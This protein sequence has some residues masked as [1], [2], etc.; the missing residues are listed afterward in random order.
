M[1]LAALVNP[2][3]GS[4]E[5]ETPPEPMSPADC[6]VQTVPPP[7]AAAVGRPLT[8]S[9]AWLDVIVWPKPSVTT[10]S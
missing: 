9:A 1:Q 10:M 4:H 3:A 8:V 6:P 5:Q 2:V 7:E